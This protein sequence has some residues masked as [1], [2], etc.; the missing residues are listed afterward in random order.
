[1]ILIRLLVCIVMLNIN[2]LNS[3]Q[4]LKN[5]ICLKL[6]NSKSISQLNNYYSQLKEKNR[7]VELTYLMKK[8]KFSPCYETEFINF[9]NLSITGGKPGYCFS[10]FSKN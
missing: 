6:N 2:L 5:D 10:S 7:L 9:S 3:S 8:Y 1:M 4:E